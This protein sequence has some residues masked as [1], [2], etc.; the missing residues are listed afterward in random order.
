LL[1]LLHVVQLLFDFDQCCRVLYGFNAALLCKH[2]NV[3][4]WFYFR[5]FGLLVAR[6]QSRSFT[7]LPRGCASVFLQVASTLFH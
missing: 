3:L 7:D 1:R 6:D 2:R 4:G 5:H